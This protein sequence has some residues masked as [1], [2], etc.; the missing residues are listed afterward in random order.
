MTPSVA[1]VP[2]GEKYEV[3]IISPFSYFP[4]AKGEKGEIGPFHTLHGGPTRSA[5][6]YRRAWKVSPYGRDTWMGKGVFTLSDRKDQTA[7]TALRAALFSLC[8]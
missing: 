4:E 1:S 8:S 2:K 5:R 7:P 6:A 3:G